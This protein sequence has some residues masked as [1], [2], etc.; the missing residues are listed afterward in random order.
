ALGGYDRRRSDRRAGRS[1]EQQFQRVVAQ[2]EA[3]GGGVHDEPSGRGAERRAAMDRVT[4]TSCRRG[5]ESRKK[6]FGLRQAGSAA[7]NPTITETTLPTAQ[8][9]ISATRNSCTMG[10]FAHFRILSPNRSASSPSNTNRTIRAAP[11]TAKRSWRE[12]CI[13]AAAI[14]NAVNG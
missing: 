3:A 14:P 10:S 7:R 13:A 11:T 12:Y 8:K 4:A 5:I 9:T 1:R 2:A 6:A